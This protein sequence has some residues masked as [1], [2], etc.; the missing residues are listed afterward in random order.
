MGLDMYL[1]KKIYLPFDKEERKKVKISGISGIEKNNVKSIVE[2]V[3]YWRKANAIH[4]WFVEHVQGANDDCNEHYVCK[5]QLLELKETCEKVLESLKKSPQTTKTIKVGWGPEGDITKE[6]KIYTDTEL[7]QELLPT[8]TG[9]FFGSKNYDE[10]YHDEWYD[11]WYIEELKETIKII[12]KII[13]KDAKENTC[14]D[15]YYQS[16]W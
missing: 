8:K 3:G 6:I 5:E 1:T 11:E 7:A 13:K 16:S 15:F 2:E 12:N 4:N 9:F 10:W 14:C